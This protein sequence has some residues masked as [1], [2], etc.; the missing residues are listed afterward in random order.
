[1]SCV[2]G[3]L[4]WISVCMACTDQN[5]TG[6][7]EKDKKFSVQPATAL[8]CTGF[9]PSL[10]LLFSLS[11]WFSFAK[12]RL[13]MKENLKNYLFLP[14]VSLNLFFHRIPQNNTTNSQERPGTPHSGGKLSGEI[15]SVAKAQADLLQ[16]NAV[17]CKAGWVPWFPCTL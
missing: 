5:K 15:Q 17:S 9:L 13:W 16:W 11:C 1:M 10:L 3:L 7:F 4:T 14:I 12:Y 8:L 6:V 2:S